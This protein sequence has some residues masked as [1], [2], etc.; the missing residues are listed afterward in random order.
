MGKKS[1]WQPATGTTK[2]LSLLPA[3]KAPHTW[4]AQIPPSKP[5]HASQSIIVQRKVKCLQSDGTASPHSGS[6]AARPTCRE[7]AAP[8]LCRLDALCVFQI[9]GYQELPSALLMVEYSGQGRDPP[10]QLPKNSSHQTKGEA[11][12]SVQFTPQVAAAGAP[13]RRSG[14]Y[15][16]H[17][18]THHWRLRVESLGLDLNPNPCDF[19]CGCLPAAV[20]QGCLIRW[21][22]QGP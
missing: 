15:F 9:H 22:T 13:I 7:E 20:R 4:L 11:M 3:A 14:P 17:T 8:C 1:K 19:P 5:L 6:I 16:S 21:P 2:P 12:P 10:V 18:C